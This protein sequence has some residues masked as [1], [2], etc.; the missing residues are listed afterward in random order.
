MDEWARIYC[1]LVVSGTRSDLNTSQKMRFARTYIMAAVQRINF[2]IKI[3]LLCGHLY[4]TDEWTEPGLHLVLAAYDCV[5]YDTHWPGLGD[6]DRPAG[7][8]III[9]ILL[10]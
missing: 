7:H 5:S 3:T 2:I 10:V 6:W 4:S 9:G 1:K 8:M